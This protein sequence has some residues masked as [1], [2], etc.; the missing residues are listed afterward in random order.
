MRGT[1][2]EE[3]PGGAPLGGSCRDRNCGPL[4]RSAV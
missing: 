1:S 3:W 4:W 2:D